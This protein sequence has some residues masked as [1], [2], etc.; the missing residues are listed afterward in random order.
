MH[1]ILIKPSPE[2]KGREK[3]SL[4]AGTYVHSSTRS[5]APP[6]PIPYCMP[7]A[8]QAGDILKLSNYEMRKEKREEE[9]EEEGEGKE[10]RM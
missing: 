1:D 2:K 9:E 8:F 5:T 6:T 7:A 4:A 10:E 3:M